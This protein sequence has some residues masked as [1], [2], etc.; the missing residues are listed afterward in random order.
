MMFLC[1]LY[2]HGKCLC[3]SCHVLFLATLSDL[4]MIFHRFELDYGIFIPYRCNL[5]FLL[6]PRSISCFYGR[7]RFFTVCMGAPTCACSVVAVIG[8]FKPVVLK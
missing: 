2:P 3:A 1:G 5:M 7:L 4:G 8:T 6:S